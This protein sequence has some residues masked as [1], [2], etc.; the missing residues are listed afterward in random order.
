MA[1][2]FEASV[3]SSALSKGPLLNEASVAYPTRGAM[4]LTEAVRRC[5]A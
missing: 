3:A 5:A 4:L 2:S 1:F